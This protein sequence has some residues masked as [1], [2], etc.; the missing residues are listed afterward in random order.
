[1]IRNFIIF[2]ILNF[3]ALAIGSLFT[4]PGVSSEWYQALDKAPWTPPGWVFGFSWTFIMICLSMYMAIAWNR[5]TFKKPLSTLYGIQ[6]FLNIIWNPIF[7]YY[8][9]ITLG[10]IIIGALTIVVGLILF[11]F[12]GQMQK[13]SLLLVPYLIWLCIA[14]SLNAYFIF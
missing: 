7:F 5:I 1:M 13:T 12:R 9:N 8:H 4:V 14:T 3:T 10:L 11:L 2:L 6:L